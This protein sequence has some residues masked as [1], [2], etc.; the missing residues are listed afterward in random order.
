MPPNSKGGT[1]SFSCTSRALTIEHTRFP[2]VD[3]APASRH[4][5]RLSALPPDIGE[6]LLRHHERSAGI[7]QNTFAVTNSSCD[8]VGCVSGVMTSPQC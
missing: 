3:V 7:R 2:L 1:V 8:G 6:G 4:A 5:H